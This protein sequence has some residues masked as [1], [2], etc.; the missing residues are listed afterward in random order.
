MSMRE[1]TTDTNQIS[2]HPVTMRLLNKR[3]HQDSKAIQDFFSWDLKDIPELTKMQDMDLASERIIKAIDEKESIGIYGDYD[4]DGTTSCAL[5]YHFFKMLGVEV[6]LFQPSRFVEGYGVHK[7]SID[8]AL[9]EGVKLLITVDCGITNLETA[10]YTHDK[11]I[12]LIITDHHKDAAPYI[13]KAFAVIN[14]NRRDEPEESE[15]RTL[16]G[17]GVAFA[18]CVDIREKLLK[19]GDKIE[20]LYPLLQFV[21]IGTICDLAK[22]GP[23]NMR[24]TRHGLK[25]IPKTTY[26]GIRVFFSPDERE[27]DMMASDQI[28]FLVGP[29]INSKGRLD[30]P[31]AALKLLI[32]KDH[33]EAFEYYSQLEISNRE[34]KIIQKEVFDEAKKKVIT[35]LKDSD[36]PITIV[37]APEWHEGVIGI[38]ASKL[39]ETFEV[40]AIVFTNAEEEGIIKASARSAGDLNIFNCLDECKD[41]FLKFGGHKAAA[42]LSMKKENFEAF[43]N[44]MNSLVSSYPEMERRVQEFYD[45]G[46]EFSEIDKKLMKELALFEPYGMGNTRPIFRMSSIRLESYQVLKDVHVKWCFTSK[47]NPKIKLNGISF[48][49]IG[50]WNTLHPEEIFSRQESEG[51]TAQFSLSINRFRGNEIIQLMVDKVFLGTI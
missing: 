20:S 47:E 46:I 25:Q 49:Y 41:L 19:R 5:F 26:A 10:E 4:V 36:H 15:L 51:I 37:Y 50:K 40:P 48:N 21:A 1:Q 32:A 17:V 13:P 3:G 45:I 30:H 23:L 16:A 33:K 31:E 11:D 42:G 12:D 9:N 29:M 44:K 43:K 22:L 34:R 27:V 7:A 35:E 39:V 24:L 6:K 38:V 18:I 28:A 14:P 8:Q 2:I